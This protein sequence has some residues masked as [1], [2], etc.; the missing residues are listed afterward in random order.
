MPRLFVA[1]V[2]AVY[3]QSLLL[4]TYR[5][6]MQHSATVRVHIQASEGFDKISH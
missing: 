2:D 3:C 6:G 4:H 1:I 5:K